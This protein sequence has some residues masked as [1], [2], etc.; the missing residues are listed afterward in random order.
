MNQP[1]SGSFYFFSPPF[2]RH[3]RQ[4]LFRMCRFAAY[5]G[6]PIFLE[7]VVSQPRHS[8][9]QQSLR[10]E[11]GKCA[12]N[13][14]G[15][16]LG[17]YSEKPEPALYREAMPAWSDD[18]L[19]SLCASVRAGLF[20]AH[21]R[22]A[23]GTPITRHNC[24]PFRHGRYLF[25]HNGQVGGYAQLRRRLESLLP[26]PLYALRKGSTDSELIFLLALAQL[27]RGEAPLAAVVTAFHQVCEV[28]RANDAD[29]KPVRF[30]A[31][32]ADGDDLY[33]FRLSSDRRSP[34]LYLR[35][36]PSGS[37]LASEPLDDDGRWRLLPEGTAM[38]LA[39]L[40]GE[41]AL[42]LRAA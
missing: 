6:E 12:T 30:S 20:F 32:L 37:T 7:E 24:H 13:G 5:L 21:V 28:A 40:T 11:E 35:D 41:Q 31:A 27:E 4:V 14:D 39:G 18:N 23:T 10:A 9:L 34:S 38:K 2:H 33:A 15:F 36:T 19:A 25:M 8:L 26:D 42:P 22:A 29:A 1:V 16:G 17:W 3:H